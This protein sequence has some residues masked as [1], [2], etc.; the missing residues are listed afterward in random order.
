MAYYDIAS[1]ITL[2]YVKRIDS[3]RHLLLPDWSPPKFIYTKSVLPF[4]LV[5]TRGRAFQAFKTSVSIHLT[6]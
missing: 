1:E 2:S 5:P 4:G 6:F 3:L